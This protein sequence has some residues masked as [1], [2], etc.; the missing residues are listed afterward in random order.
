M[1]EPVPQP[2]AVLVVVTALVG[3]AV[4]VTVVATALVGIVVVVTG[5]IRTVVVVTVVATA[6]VG[7]VVVGT[8]VVVTVVVVTVA[9]VVA[10]AVVVLGHKGSSSW[11]SGLSPPYYVLMYARDNVAEATSWQQQPVADT[12]IEAATVALRMLADATRLRLMTQLTG[13]EQDV[14][15][16]TG[17]VGAARPAVSQHLAKLRLAGLVT[18]RRN[19]RRALYAINGPHVHRLVVEA[20]QMAEH[21]AAPGRPPHHQPSPR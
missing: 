18:V 6:L 16:L 14:T 15:A 12:V 3:T 7:T 19:G 17:G 11:C 10:V 21:Q 9:G 2:G 20:I 8:V 1:P 5:L 4:V 13:G